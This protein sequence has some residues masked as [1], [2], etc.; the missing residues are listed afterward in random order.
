MAHG[1]LVHTKSWS[2]ISHILT[3]RM[4]LTV[5]DYTLK[6]LSTDILWLLYNDIIINRNYSHLIA[7]G[8]FR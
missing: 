6:R 7:Y 5:H 8:Y 3:R 4:M 1:N 2:P